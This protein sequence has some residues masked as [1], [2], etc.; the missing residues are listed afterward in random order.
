LRIGDTGIAPCAAKARVARF[1]T[2]A[3]PAKELLEG[4]INAYRNILQYLR[5]HRRQRWPGG[6]EQ[7][8]GRLLVVQTQRL[9]PL[10]PG[11]AS[12][13]QQMIVQ[14]AALLKL[15]LKETL[16]LFVRVQAIL[17]RLT[18]ATIFKLKHAC[19][20]GERPFIPMPERRGLLAAEREGKYF[21]RPCK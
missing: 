21:L 9:L 10:L 14:P 17:E 20:Q 8:Q 4:Q 1:L 2:S 19:C 15:L 5:L 7:R 16:L 3:Y 11:V 6:F 18:R 13:G 12:C